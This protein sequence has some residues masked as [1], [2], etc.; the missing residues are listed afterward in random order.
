M[1]NAYKIVVGKPQDKTPVGKPR[2]R[3][4]DIKIDQKEIGR[5]GEDWIYLAKNRTSRELL[6]TQ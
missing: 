5:E 3:W 4:E 2:H 1:R 6:R